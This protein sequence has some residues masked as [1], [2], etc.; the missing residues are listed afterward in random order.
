LLLNLYLH[1]IYCLLLYYIIK[2]SFIYIYIYESSLNKR[3]DP[4]TSGFTSFNRVEPS[5]YEFTSFNNRALISC[6]RV[7]HLIIDSSTSRV[8]SS[9]SRVSPRVAQLV[10]TP[11]SNTCTNGSFKILHHSRTRSTNL[12]FIHTRWG[13]KFLDTNGSSFFVSCFLF[14]FPYQLEQQ[15]WDRLSEIDLIK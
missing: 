12:S 4:Y 3:V 8:Y 2:I 5:L 11:S 10:Y 6:S 14:F 1:I 15:L 9:R 7:A 13:H